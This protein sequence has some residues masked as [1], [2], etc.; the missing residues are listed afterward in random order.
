MVIGA[1]DVDEFAKAPFELIAVVGDIRSKIGE[2]AIALDHRPVLIVAKS[3][4][5]KPFS[6]VVGV[7][8]TPLAQQPD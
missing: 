2:L 3:G 8:Q 6:T 5:L 7:N 1:P 4:R